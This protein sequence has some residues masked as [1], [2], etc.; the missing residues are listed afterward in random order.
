MQNETIG[1]LQQLV[2][3]QRSLL[4][5]VQAK[6][7]A[8]QNQEWLDGTDIKQLLHISDSTL[9]R[10]VK[11]QKLRYMQVGGKKYYLREMLFNRKDPT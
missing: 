9:Y 10:L 1:L 4:E 3:L 6:G 2:Q 11:Q 7:L 5:C 8:T